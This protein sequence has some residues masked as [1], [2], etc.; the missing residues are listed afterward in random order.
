[1]EYTAARGGVV[2]T[3]NGQTVMKGG[4]TAY[5][6][7]VTRRAYDSIDFLLRNRDGIPV[8]A[9]VKASG[10]VVPESAVGNAPTPTPAPATRSF[11]DN[12][13]DIMKEFQGDPK[14]LREALVARAN[15]L[16][17]TVGAAKKA[18]AT[19][20]SGKKGDMLIIV[21]GEV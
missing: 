5:A 17:D 12:M 13:A 9:V 8:K 11:A 1:M 3:P 10:N 18:A 20:V 6:D 2:R 4:E 7:A 19:A 21:R 14:A 16:A 15:E